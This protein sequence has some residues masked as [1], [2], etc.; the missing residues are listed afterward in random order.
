[1]ITYYRW[2]ILEPK[3]ELPEPYIDEYGDTHSLPNY[4]SK[5][6]AIKGLREFLNWDCPIKNEEFTLLKIYTT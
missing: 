3:M 5:Y 1:M 4:D 2:H 6:D